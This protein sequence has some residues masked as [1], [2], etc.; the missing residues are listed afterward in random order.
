MLRVGELLVQGL[1]FVFV[2]PDKGDGIIFIE[3]EEGLDLFFE[4]PG[5]ACS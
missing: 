1:F 4:K 2:N 5:C 3:F